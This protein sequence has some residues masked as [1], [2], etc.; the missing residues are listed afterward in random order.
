MNITIQL[1][2]YINPIKRINKDGSNCNI[3]DIITWSQKKGQ[4][5]GIIKKK[6]KSCIDVDL[7]IYKIFDQHLI[8]ESSTKIDNVCY[9]TLVFTR[10][11]WVI[12][13]NTFG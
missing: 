2:D 12:K 6:H 13:S 1:N 7:Y 9:N 4:M 8:L 10:K 3:G 5:F 11:I